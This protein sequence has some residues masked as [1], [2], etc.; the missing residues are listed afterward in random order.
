MSPLA[1]PAQC[2]YRS[3]ARHVK[4]GCDLPTGGPTD[5]AL[6]RVPFRASGLTAA[7]WA[8]FLATKGRNLKRLD[9][10][11]SS[12]VGTL[13]L[14]LCPQAQLHKGEKVHCD[15]TTHQK[16]H[17]LN[18]GKQHGVKLRDMRLDHMDAAL[19][20]YGAEDWRTKEQSW[21]DEQGR[22]GRPKSKVTFRQEALAPLLL[23]EHQM[24][25]ESADLAAAI[26][27]SAKKLLPRFAHLLSKE[28]R[29]VLARVYNLA[30]YDE[31]W[32]AEAMNSAIITLVVKA[33]RRWEPLLTD[34]PLK[35]WQTRG[36]RGLWTSDRIFPMEWKVWKA[37]ICRKGRL[38]ADPRRIASHFVQSTRI[39]FTRRDSRHCGRPGGMMSKIV[40]FP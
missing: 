12:N 26:E 28:Q 4:C 30:S 11:A 33:S 2:L 1:A 32:S 37:L 27:Q 23:R 18:L 10:A 34:N 29:A 22:L 7:N 9:E 13:V 31:G 35:K 40:P 21:L 20:C 15:E 36:P 17:D 3:I 8:Y 6:P 38:L 39:R 5:T 25:D 14:S 19:D 16:C 24:M